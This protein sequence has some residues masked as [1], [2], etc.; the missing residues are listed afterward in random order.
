MKPSRRLTWLVTLAVACGTAAGGL[1]GPKMQAT[2]VSG[3]DEGDVQSNLKDF[4][5][6]YDIV[7]REYADQ[8]DPNKAIYGPE[9]AAAVGAIPGMLRVLDPHS[10]FFDPHTF[11]Q[12]REE[13]EG[14]YYG[15]GM[16]IAPRLDKSGKLATFVQAPIP[17]SGISGVV[18]R[19]AAP[20]FAATSAF[21]KAERS[22]SF[23]WI[24]TIFSC[25]IASR[26]ASR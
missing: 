22:S 5:R 21:Q 25:R 18:A 4:T 10:N 9:N 15:V 20:M 8:V 6:I 11:A 3:G 7:Q 26:G 16:T 24:P 1:Y 13:Q 12:L 19:N 17:G 23:F 2:T 14:K